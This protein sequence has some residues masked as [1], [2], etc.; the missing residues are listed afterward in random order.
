MRAGTVLEALAETHL[1]SLLV[2]RLVDIVGNGVTDEVRRAAAAAGAVRGWVRDVRD[3]YR[4]PDAV[5]VPIRA[6]GGTRIKILEAFSYRRPVV[7]TSI[8]AEG[9]DA[10]D[11]EE[12]LIADTP[13]RFVQACVRL[14]TEGELRE[15]LTR[16]A[17]DLVVRSY[18]VE[19]LRRVVAGF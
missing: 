9:I 1:I 4:D 11:Q 3:C 13:E 10:R 14:I 17:F 12:I 8:G 16:N 7:S 19:T 18:S 6:G 5:V 2:V 15:R